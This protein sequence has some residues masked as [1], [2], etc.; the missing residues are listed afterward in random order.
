M[1]L[2]LTLTFSV[3][4]SSVP[5][6]QLAVMRFTTTSLTSMAPGSLNTPGAKAAYYVFHAA[7]E[8]LTAATLMS[9]N[10]RQMFHTGRWGD[11]RLKDRKPSTAARS[12]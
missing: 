11:R 9:L 1:P 5:I 2:T 8:Y 3:Y 6:Y 4:Q 10:V 12:G 7:P